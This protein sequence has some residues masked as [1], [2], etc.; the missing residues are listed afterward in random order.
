MTL[1]IKTVVSGQ[2]PIKGETRAKI[3]DQSGSSKKVQ[4][5]RD[6]EDKGQKGICPAY[7]D[8]ETDQSKTRSQEA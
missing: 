2:T 7:P 5:N 1:F 4:E 6:R 8:E 3:E